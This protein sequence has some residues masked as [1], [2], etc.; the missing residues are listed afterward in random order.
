MNIFGTDIVKKKNLCKKHQEVD[1]D[2]TA[3]TAW[4]L[5]STANKDRDVI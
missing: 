3:G 4:F 1:E 2:T 5:L